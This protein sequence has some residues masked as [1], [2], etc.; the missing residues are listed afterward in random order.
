[1]METLRDSLDDSVVRVE[2][3]LV[4][5]FDGGEVE[6]VRSGGNVVVGVF[7]SGAVEVSPLVSA[8]LESVVVVVEEASVVETV[9]EA[10]VEG[11]V[12][13]VDVE[14]VVDVSAI[15]EAVVEAVVEAVIVI[16]GDVIVS[17]VVEDTALSF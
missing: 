10:V 7:R 11:A 2:V 3:C 6:L 13:A 12:K 5:V 15:I 1:M 4:V 17:V 16:I 14:A 9:A 8:V